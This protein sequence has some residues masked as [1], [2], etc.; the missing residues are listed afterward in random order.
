M[1][2]PL[3]PAIFNAALKTLFPE[4]RLK[5]YGQRDQP[6]WAWLT[7]NQGFGGRKGEVPIR[8][9]PGGGASH[10]FADA[11]A[12]KSGSQYTFFE[13]TRKRDYLIIS[14]DRE[15]LEASEGD[16]KNSYMTAKES[17]VD[18]GFMK[19]VQRLA[20]DLQ[21]DGTG[22]MGTVLTTPTAT[23]FTTAQVSLTHVEPGDQI[24]FAASPFTALRTGAGAY[25]YATVLSVNYDTN[26]IAVDTTKGD[27]L[28]GAGSI[29]VLAADQ[30][31][32]K[33]SFGNSVSGTNAWIPTNRSNLST[34]FNSVDR[35]VFPSRLAGIF[36]DGSTFGLAECLERA[37][38]RGKLEGSM[39]DMIWLNY[40]RFA[41]LSLELGAKVQ[42]EAVKLGAFAFDSLKIYAGGR[43]IRVVGDQNF[44]DTT[45][46]AVNKESWYFWSLKGAPRFLTRD[47][48][49]G[50]ML[51][52]P[53]SDGFE[54]RIGWNGELVCRSPLDNIRITLPT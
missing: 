7:K 10:T 53:G 34:P 1:A 37:I 3:T 41:D 6:F 16:S 14:I 9:A 33:G 36:F 8:Y 40:N 38:A 23:T 12:A 47:S 4:K 19:I 35:S 20:A 27:S 26:T 43:E 45:A 51:M 54:I 44:A 39:P 49:N 30:F 22:N 46:L 11:L 42:R 50:D 31:Y 25:G 52:D 48:G 32:F 17:E 18:S 2:N 29:G 28:T 15:A 13:V 24:V 5:L 21:S